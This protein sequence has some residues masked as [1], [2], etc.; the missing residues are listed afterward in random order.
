METI[1]NEANEN[2]LCTLCASLLK[3]LHSKFPDCKETYACLQSM[4][5]PSEEALKCTDW[6]AALSCSLD[7]KK[8]KY[9]K[10]IERIISK[11]ASRYHALMHRDIIS[12]VDED[13]ALCVF[14]SLKEKLESSRLDEDETLFV[15]DTLVKITKHAY[16]AD[17]VEMP[18]NPSRN[19]IEE[20]IKK[21]K[22]KAEHSSSVLK[23]FQIHFENLL[24]MLGG[25]KPHASHDEKSIKNVMKK[26]EEF[27]NQKCGD[28][29]NFDLCASSNP[30]VLSS[31]M[32]HIPE[33]NSAST[34][35]FDKKMWDCVNQMNK[36]CTVHKNV[37]AKMMGRIESMASRLAEDIMSGKADMSKLD[38]S[39][40]GQEVLAG[41]N[42]EDMS[43]FASNIENLLP[44]VQSSLNL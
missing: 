22:E 21:R 43:N 15:W 40:I 10:A 42:E 28:E 3:F 32:K 29:S 23:S 6:V 36:F 37:P 27:I 24:T 20:S 38:L 30:V 9:A 1:K 26:W 25:E 17:G 8:T 44:V 33:L 31:M 13:G 4:N 39:E 5:N 2:I 18:L 12:L 19:Q 34:V 16:E 11:P 41:C 14:K 7:Y 35:E